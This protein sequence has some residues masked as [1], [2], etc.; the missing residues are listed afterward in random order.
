MDD[1]HLVAAWHERL[2]QLHPLADLL[3]PHLTNNAM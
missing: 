2:Q 3:P 1:P